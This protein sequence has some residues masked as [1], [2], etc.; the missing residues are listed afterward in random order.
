LDPDFHGPLKGGPLS[1]R[2]SRLITHLTG[3]WVSE[4]EIIKL[5]RR[6]CQHEQAS[7]F[8]LR[9]PSPRGASLLS[10]DRS[11]Q[12]EHFAPN[13]SLNAIP[14]LPRSLGFTTAD[15]AP[16]SIASSPMYVSITSAS[17]CFFV[18]NC[19]LCFSASALV[20]N[21]QTLATHFAGGCASSGGSGCLDSPPVQCR[22]DRRSR[23]LEA[24][25]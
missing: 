19:W 20:A 3:P 10:I 1:P 12:H 5:G 14:S 22:G 21:R 15:L 11:K 17:F 6:L 18:V 7:S 24:L 9:T 8:G 4:S 13:L 16:A 25:A 2:I 23:I